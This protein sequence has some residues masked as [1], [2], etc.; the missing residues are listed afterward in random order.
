MK[1]PIV[2][3]LIPVYNVEKYLRKCLDSVV[4]QTLT[5]IEIICVNDGSTDDSLKI[6]EEYR[7]I[8]SRIKIINKAN[9]GLPSARNAAFDVA[10]GRYVGFVDSDDYIEPNM[11]EKLVDVA[12]YEESEVVICGANIFPEEPRA[13]AWL[14]NCLSPWYKHYDS[15]DPGLLYWRQDTNPFL[16]RVLVSKQLIDRENL[17]L[18]EDIIVGEDKVFQAKLYPRAKGISVIPDKLYNYYWCRP[19]SLMS[20][21]VYGSLERRIFNHSKLVARIGEDIISAVSDDPTR[22]GYLEW[23]ISFIYED[24][25]YL[26]QNDKIKVAEKLIPIWKNV[27]YYLMM[28]EL[29]EWKQEAFKYIALFEKL[30]AFSIKL[31]IV[32]PIE[33]KS[34]YVEEF[35]DEQKKH[36]DSET[37]IIIINNGMK[38]EN[39]IKAQKWLYSEPH[40]RLYNTPSHLSYAEALN[41]GI[42]L[43]K[44]EYL[45]FMDPQ[46]WY[47]NE[48]MLKNWYQE[49]FDKKADICFC[50]FVKKVSKADS[51]MESVISTD[52][53]NDYDISYHD[54]L[55]RKAFLVDN[56]LEFKDYALITGFVFMCKA[57]SMAKTVCMYDENVYI[58][59]KMHTADW[60]STEKCE[61]LLEGLE[62]LAKLSVQNKDV[63]LHGKVFSMLNGDLFKQLIVNNTKPYAMPMEKCPNGENS[64]IK[65]VATLLKIVGMADYD[66]LKQ[67]GFSDQQSVVET[68][69]EIINERHIFLSKIS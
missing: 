3:V 26:N 62:E 29:P 10:R 34:R 37:E 18:D 24:F 36:M 45:M 59:R 38:N 55:F 66:M 31:S 58:T 1:N 12:E 53:L 13:D 49:A 54:C 64:Q 46:D 19:D 14:Y 56:E 50:N 60:L 15:F 32:V 51:G 47:S 39:F 27:G 6:L 20:K 21:Q 7:S 67:Y 65:T 9:G 30:D 52:A 22:K 4:N 57:H 16:W 23:A 44:G 28:N 5:N 69:S 25:I 35:I 41:C 42:D 17:R 68:L 8:D 33:Q 40:V 43:A 2:S 63:Y 61:G 48:G 11:F